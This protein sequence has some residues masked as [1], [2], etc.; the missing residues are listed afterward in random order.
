MTQVL[1]TVLLPLGA[2]KRT[3]GYRTG[4]MRGGRSAGIQAK[5]PEGTEID[6]GRPGERGGCVK[7][8]ERQNEG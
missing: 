4:H 6:G 7:G 8:K 2:L 5:C 1:D 3:R